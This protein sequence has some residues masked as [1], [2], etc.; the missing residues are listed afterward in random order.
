MKGVYFL[1]ND[2]VFDLVVAFLESFRAHNPRLPL[3]LIPYDDDIARVLKL[4]PVYAFG[5][6]E[7]GE[8][9]G[10][11]D[12]VGFSILGRRCGAFRK[13]AAW[14]G[15]FE[16]FAYIDIDTIVLRGLEPLFCH[17][18]EY[19]FVAAQSHLRDGGR[20]VW[21]QSI[22]RSP[23]LDR[24]QIAFAANSGLF[25]SQRGDWFS[26]FTS[27]SSI[28]V[29]RDLRPHMVLNCMEQPFLN[30][31]VVTSGMR[32]SS[33]TEIKRTA[34]DPRVCLEQW[35]GSRGGKVRKGTVHFPGRPPVLLM[36]WAGKWQPT[37]MDRWWRTLLTKLGWRRG[38]PAT[39]YFLPYKALW[40]Y[41]RC[42]GEAAASLGVSP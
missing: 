26:R 22:H 41:Y 1:A 39:R 32:F 21:K 9:L 28:E 23:L 12:H 19:D 42:R 38:F 33:L 16:C 20:W 13:L 24:E 25:L 2:R 36:H 31:C 37:R 34:G 40:E 6:I 8:V 15:P 7:D 3:A 18:S 4:A 27:T 35:A 17:L 11:C 10:Q 5:L 14:R 29:A 30:Y